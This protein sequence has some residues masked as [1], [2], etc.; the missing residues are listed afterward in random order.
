MVKKR[1][2]SMIV[3]ERFFNTFE[4]ERKKEQD[5][6]RQKVGGMFNLTQ[7]NFTELLAIKNFRFQV[8]KGRIVRKVRRRKIR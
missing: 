8:P 5:R 6:L 3:D 1:G 7:K 2:V 4:R